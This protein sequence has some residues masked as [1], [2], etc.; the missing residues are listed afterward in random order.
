[1]SSWVSF[2]CVNKT[3]EEDGIADEKDWSVVSDEIPVALLSVKLDSKTARIA[4]SVSRATFPTD[5]GKADGERRPLADL[6]EN[7]SFAVFR[8][9]M[10][11]FEVSKRT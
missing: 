9:V 2:L 3:W 10:R 1:M 11:D 6:R 4:G 5:G 7:G 8:D